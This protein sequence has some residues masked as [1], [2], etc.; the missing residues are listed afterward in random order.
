MDYEMPS[1][2]QLKSA[3]L[4]SIIFSIYHKSFKL[5]MQL[6]FLNWEF[7]KYAQTRC[8]CDYCTN[9][10]LPWQQLRPPSCVY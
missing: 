8:N 3:I 9:V 7:Y 1:I 6:Q 2:I 4:K 5:V 10:L